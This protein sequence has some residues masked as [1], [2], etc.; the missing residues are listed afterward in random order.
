MRWLFLL[1]CLSLDVSAKV[2][3]FVIQ[4]KDRSVTVQAPEKKRELFSVLLENNSLS[5]QV[6]K[7]AV[8]GKTLKFVS[9]KSGATETV[10]IENKSGVNVKFV[11][12]SPAFQ[13]IE[14]IFGKKN[15][16]IPPKE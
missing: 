14:L 4:V 1:L 5:D 12:I 8:N 6:G 11:P 3:T 15:Y 16:E 9:I 13:D 10:E 2:E 7:F